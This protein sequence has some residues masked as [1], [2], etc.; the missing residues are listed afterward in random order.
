MLARD[1]FVAMTPLLAS[2]LREMG[3][4]DAIV[5]FARHA[6]PADFARAAPRVLDAAGDPAAARI[7]A[8]A[9]AAVARALDRLEADGPVPIVFTGGL[10]PTFARRLGPRYPTL[11]RP[12]KGSA[13]DGALALARGLL[14]D[15]AA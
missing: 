4:P 1:G 13:L 7:L 3:S 2:V 10:G 8:E 11:L 9:D 14:Q 12:A 5:A 15:P 6:T